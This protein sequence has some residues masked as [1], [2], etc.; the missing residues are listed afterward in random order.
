MKTLKEK[1][2]LQDF[3]FQINCHGSCLL[4][5]DSLFKIYLTRNTRNDKYYAIKVFQLPKMEE[6]TK[7]TLKTQQE[8]H[9]K[10]RHKNVAKLAAVF[11]R[12]Q[13]VYHVLEYNQE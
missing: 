7:E 5:D 13:E 8:V 9:F 3:I 2:K 12:T 1:L 11:S 10:L 6:R 4:Q